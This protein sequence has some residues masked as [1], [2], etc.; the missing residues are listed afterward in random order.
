MSEQNK[1][2][3]SLGAYVVTKEKQTINITSKL[4]KML[5]DGFKNQQ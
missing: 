2:I 3:C 4:N 5:K 1:Y